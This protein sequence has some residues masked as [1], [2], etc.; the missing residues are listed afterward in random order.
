MASNGLTGARCFLTVFCDALRQRLGGEVLFS[1]VPGHLRK[2]SMDN[3]DQGP[4]YKGAVVLYMLRRL[5]G[6][7]AFFKGLRR[8][9]VGLWRSRTWPGIAV[10]S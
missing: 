5:L 10:G 1:D 9:H 2:W 7:D 4:V 8:F 6:D 3:S